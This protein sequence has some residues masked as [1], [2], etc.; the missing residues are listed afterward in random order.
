MQEKDTDDRCVDQ[1]VTLSPKQALDRLGMQQHEMVA[2]LEE[3]TSEY[4]TN[5]SAFANLRSIR[6]R[7]KKVNKNLYKRKPLAA[8]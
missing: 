2:H 6:Y 7:K 5:I 3:L 1:I 8:F 4:V